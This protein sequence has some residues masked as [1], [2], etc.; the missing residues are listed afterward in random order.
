MSP[1]DRIRSP[2]LLSKVM[3]AEE[4]AA[5]IPLGANV[6]MSGFTG[7][8]YPKAVPQALAERLAAWPPA[9]QR[10][11]PRPASACG[12]GPPPRRSS[13]VHWPRST[14]LKNACPT[15]PTRPCAS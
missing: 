4:A 3:S 2:E 1:T 14:A 5:L 13:M 11:T 8:G 9:M 7:A 15:N 6:G 12:P 10:A